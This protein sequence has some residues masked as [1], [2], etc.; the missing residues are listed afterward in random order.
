MSFAKDGPEA[1]RTSHLL[2]PVPGQSL[3]CPH[4]RRELCPYAGTLQVNLNSHILLIAVPSTLLNSPVVTLPARISSLS[5]NPSP[6]RR[7]MSAPSHLLLHFLPLVRTPLE[8]LVSRKPLLPSQVHSSMMIAAPV[9]VTEL[10][11]KDTIRPPQ[12]S[13]FRREWTS[14]LVPCHPPNVAFVSWQCH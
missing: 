8:N 6:K 11:S 4:P 3:L 12:S 1:Q 13:K 7:A 2:A 10:G 14:L 9:S 5:S